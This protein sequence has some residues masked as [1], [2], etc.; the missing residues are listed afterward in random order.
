[1]VSGTNSGLT[2][3]FVIDY[4]TGALRRLTNDKNGDMQP[5][6]SPDGQQ[7]AFTTERGE[8]VDLDML[9]L[10]PWRIA[11]YDFR[12][13]AIEVVPGQ[14]GHNL[15]PQWSPDGKSIAYISDRTG[16]ANVFM[17][18]VAS[19]EHYQLTNVIGSVS[20][21]TEYSPAITWARH[22][23]KLAFTYFEDGDYT[24]W[25]TQNPRR[26]KGEPFRAKPTTDGCRDR[27]RAATAA[28]DRRPG[29]G[30]HR[31]F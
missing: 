17:F 19:K 12:T 5:A 16:I 14:G 7:I 13:G 27:E 9:R 3:L 1:V 23:D 28:H 6:W 2:D 22:A 30:R 4:E 21:I 10:A 24:V 25:M 26:L 31:R 15:N 20:G 11:V 8:N 29:S 18:D